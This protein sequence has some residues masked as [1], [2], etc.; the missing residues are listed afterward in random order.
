MDLTSQFFTAQGLGLLQYSCLMLCFFLSMF[1][2]MIQDVIALLI[3]PQTTRLRATESHRIKK[4]VLQENQTTEERKRPLCS[5]CRRHALQEE[6]TF[7]E[8][9]S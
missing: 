3:L 6:K 2:R 5:N 4:D 7:L 9:F 8:S 1:P